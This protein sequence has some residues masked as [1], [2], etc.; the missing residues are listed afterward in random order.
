MSPNSRLWDC[1]GN[2]NHMMMA[3]RSVHPGG[4]QATMV[5]GAVKFFSNSIDLNTWR[6]MGGAKDGVPVTFE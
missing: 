1:G 2:S 5:D 6:F 3:A 4:V